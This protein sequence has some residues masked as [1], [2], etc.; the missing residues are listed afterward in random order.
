M[1]AFSQLGS[2]KQVL[3]GDLSHVFMAG[4]FNLAM[5][6]TAAVFSYS[7]EFEEEVEYYI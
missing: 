1:E 6:F 2:L 3:K 7:D 5:C 4:V